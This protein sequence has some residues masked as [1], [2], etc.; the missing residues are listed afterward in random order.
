MRD[1]KCGELIL[2]EKPLIFFR[3]GPTW[4]DWAQEQFHAL[5]TAAKEA[6][7]SLQDERL[8]QG[9]KSLPGIVGTNCIGCSGDS[10]DGVVCGTI[11]RINH[12]C[13]PNCEQTWDKALSEE[14]IFASIDI[15]AGDELSISYVPPFLSRAERSQMLQGSYKFQCA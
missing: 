9:R 1:I 13:V 10:F 8:F 7:W 12:S 15:R 2:S 11:S 14:R 6:L 3:E 4:K 5:P